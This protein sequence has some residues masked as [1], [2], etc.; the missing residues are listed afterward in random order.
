[1]QRKFAADTFAECGNINT[2]VS[3]RSFASGAEGPA[4]E[5]LVRHMEP[6]LSR[7]A[8]QWSR[9]DRIVILRSCVRVQRSSY[10]VIYRDFTIRSCE[11][12]WWGEG[13]N[14]GNDH[15]SASCCILVVRWARTR[16]TK[17]LHTPAP[18][19]RSPNP[20][21]WR[22]QVRNDENCGKILHRRKRSAIALMATLVQRAPPPPR[23]DD[24]LRW[25][26]TQ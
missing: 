11:C 4:E 18:P 19:S 6:R 26:L 21:V 3:H 2:E 25:R 23:T 16:R 9:L 24:R 1:V 12:G 10:V 13:E 22:L 17:R 14:A 8:S 5:K 20:S 7:T 15:R